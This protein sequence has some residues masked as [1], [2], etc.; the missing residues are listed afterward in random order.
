M[1]MQ[2]ASTTRAR[3]YL[4]MLVF[5]VVAGCGSSQSA[6]DAGKRSVAGVEAAARKF[7]TNV[8]SAHY[9]EA[10]EG[11]TAQAQASLQREE[12]GGCLGTIA[13]LYGA[14]GGQ[15]NK[16]FESVLPKL[17]V[18]G[19]VASITYCAQP[20]G[21]PASARKCVSQVYARYEHG[22]WRVETAIL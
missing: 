12:P 5:V 6:G 10:C 15:V 1:G 22:Q 7:V 21:K 4:P 20:R 18:H 14:L 13:Y 17:E 3:R 11:F 9:R 19:D 16:F 2:P 8:Q